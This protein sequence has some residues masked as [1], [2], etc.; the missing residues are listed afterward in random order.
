MRLRYTNRDAKERQHNTTY[1]ALTI[2]PKYD[3]FFVARWGEAG[4]PF[5]IPGHMSRTTG[6]HDPLVLRASDL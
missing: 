1:L 6:V 3:V 4:E 5:V 2:I